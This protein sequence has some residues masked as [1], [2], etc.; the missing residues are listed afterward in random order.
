[1]PVT[2]DSATIVP[3]AAPDIPYFGIRRKFNV[4]FVIAPHITA[5]NDIFS[6]L[7]ADKGLPKSV[8]VEI[9]K[10]N[11][12]RIFIGICASKNWD[13]ENA[14]KSGLDN[15]NIPTV[16]GMLNIQKIVIDFSN[17]DENNSLSFFSM[18]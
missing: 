3:I 10:T 17:N 6:F 12:E 9:I 15:K 16:I 1:M 2:N 11:G 4:T 5:K 7:I 18:Q 14:D 8:A 13:P